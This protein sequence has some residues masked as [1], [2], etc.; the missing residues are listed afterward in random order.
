M[1]NIVF[2]E[3]EQWFLDKGLITALPSATFYI[4]LG[5]TADVSTLPADN[6]TL[7]AGITELSG[8]GYARQAVTFATPV[9]GAEYTSAGAQVT[10]TFTGTPT[11]GNATYAFLTTVASGTV[12]KLIGAV[13]LGISRGFINGDT[14]KVTYTQQAADE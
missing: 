9:L 13:N 10:F 7:A 3:G 2:D 6:A 4:G 1:A 8:S 5:N 11:G 12:G 14:E